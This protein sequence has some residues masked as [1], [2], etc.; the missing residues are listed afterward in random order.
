MKTYRMLSLALGLIAGASV[1][2]AQTI[3]TPVVPVTSVVVAPV[4]PVVVAPVPTT[5]SVTPVPATRIQASISLNAASPGAATLVATDTTYGQYLGMPVLVFDVKATG[6]TLHLRTVTVNMAVSG[7]GSVGAAYL[8]QGSAQ[9]ASASVT[10]GVATFANITN[11]TAGA[12]SPVNTTLPYMIKVDVTGVSS[13]I[14]VTASTGT[15]QTILSSIDA[16][17]SVSGSAQGNSLTVINKGPMVTSVGTP[18]ITMTNITP[19]PA[20]VPTV[21]YMATFNVNV[22][23]VGTDVFIGL[24][25]AS[26]P[27][28]SLTSFTIVKN[29]AP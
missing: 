11:G 19:G 5:T 24:P 29:G 14:I 12:T 22:Q 27:A 28:I 2:I 1:I 16:T 7:V 13:Y 26:F 3:P 10:A 20:T 9:I 25:A 21:A 18:T 17:V 4:T 8:F 15:T 23:A 6:D